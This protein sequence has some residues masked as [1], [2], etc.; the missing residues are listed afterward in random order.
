MLFEAFLIGFVGSLHCVTMCGPLAVAV[1]KIGRNTHSTIALYNV[2]RVITYASLGLL[3]GLLGSVINIS[4]YQNVL[5]LAVGSFILISAIGLFFHKKI[6]ITPVT[7]LV[8]R[9]K[10]SI[11][12]FLKKKGYS[13]YLTMGILNGFLPCG[14]VYMAVA[15]SLLQT[16]IV[17]SVEFMIFFG[18]GTFPS[19]VFSMN[20]F[21]AINSKI[22]FNRLVPIFLSIVGI[23]LIIRGLELGIPYLSPGGSGHH[24]LGG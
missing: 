24:H 19:M 6:N 9:L 4:H 7:L 18:L 17:Q 3:A 14:L 5:S 23:L 15:A 2:G 20:I 13:A 21:R 8:M 10:S 11:S 12:Y 22:S 1:N 16:S